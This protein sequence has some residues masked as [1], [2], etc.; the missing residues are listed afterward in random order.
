MVL[1]ILF[2][3][4]PFMVIEAEIRRISINGYST[5]VTGSKLFVSIFGFAFGLKRG[6]EAIHIIIA[7]LLLIFS[8]VCAVFF[9][10]QL[11]GKGERRNLKKP[12]IFV[13][14]ESVAFIAFGITVSILCDSSTLDDD[15][16]FVFDYKIGA[17]YIICAILMAAL[18]ALTITGYVLVKK[19]GIVEEK[20][21]KARRVKAATNDDLDRLSK[22]KNLLDSGAIT[23]EEF[24]E[25]KR[26]LLFS[27]ETN[28]IKV[29]ENHIL[30]DTQSN[31]YRL[32]EGASSVNPESLQVPLSDENKEGFIDKKADSAVADSSS[33][34][35]EVIQILKLYKDLYDSNLISKE[36]FDA[37][38]KKLL[39]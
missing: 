16:L 20:A 3:I 37:Q 35:S 11:F 4:K 17:V 8:V 28:S 39:G 1:I 29:N 12:S 36:E 24:E 30:E 21:N 32:E 10:I 19:R 38:K 27:G 6:V 34:N 22:L 26:R 18:I 7:W 14:L 2:C 13:I 15:Y 33:K 31:D 23:K 5:Y 9:I 25:H